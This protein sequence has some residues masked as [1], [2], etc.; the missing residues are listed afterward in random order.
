MD[1]SWWPA[2]SSSSA[3][4]AARSPCP[5]ITVVGPSGKPS[6]C[7]RVSAEYLIRRSRLAVARSTAQVQ[8]WI[9]RQ[10]AAVAE[11]EQVGAI[12]QPSSTSGVNPSGKSITFLQ[13]GGGGHAFVL[14]YSIELWRMMA[15]GDHGRKTALFDQLIDEDLK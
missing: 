4:V 9:H 11:I 2:R 14:Y 3:A 7:R 13:P 6:A 1:R 15:P 12:T 8:G 5:H 10:R